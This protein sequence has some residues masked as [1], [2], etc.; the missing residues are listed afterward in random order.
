VCCMTPTATG[1]SE[2]RSGGPGVAE[3]HQATRPARRRSGCS[4]AASPGRHWPC[5][6]QG[7]QQDLGQRDRV[8]GRM[9]AEV[10]HP[11]A[12]PQARLHV[13][14]VC[15]TVGFGYP[16]SNP[17]PATPAETAFQTSP[18]TVSCC[19]FAVPWFPAETGHLRL[20]GRIGPTPK[21]STPAPTRS[22]SEGST[23]AVAG[24]PFLCGAIAIS[25]RSAGNHRANLPRHLR[26]SPGTVFAVQL[27]ELTPKTGT[28]S[29]PYFALQ[30]RSRWFEPTY[31]HGDSRS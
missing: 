1:H 23:Y 28:R 31:A 14:A 5:S 25:D 21:P 15:K 12:Y 8:T 13:T 2:L 3:D 20:A 22:P 18:E 9:R 19:S 26:T 7:D 6:G 24:V 17:G 27:H 29:L 11:A 30:A 10:Q 4:P 16:S